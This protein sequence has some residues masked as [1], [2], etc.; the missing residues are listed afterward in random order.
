MEEKD[1]KAAFEMSITTLVII[2][3]AV[4]ILILGLVFVRQIFGVAT[5]SVSQVD[6]QVRSQLQKLFGETGRD[7]VVYTKE[8]NIKPTGES[9]SIAFAARR[10]GGGSVSDLKYKVTLTPGRGDCIEKNGESVVESWFI[11]PRALNQPQNFDS[12]EVDTAYGDIVVNVPKGTALCSQ[13]VKVTL[14]FNNREIADAFT[15]NVVRGGLF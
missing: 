10:P 8:V 11:I 15:L 6:L 9:I 12:Y 3:I 1:K 5:R 4:V 14:M 2:V 13:R 7:I